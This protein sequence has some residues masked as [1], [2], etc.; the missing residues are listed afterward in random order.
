MR[1]IIEEDKKTPEVL[2]DFFRLWSESKFFIREM[3]PYLH[4]KVQI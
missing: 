1:N 3:D 4:L 2:P